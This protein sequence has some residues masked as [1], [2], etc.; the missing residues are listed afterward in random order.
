MWDQIGK[1]PQNRDKDGSS[2]NFFS[3]IAQMCYFPQAMLESLG[4]CNVH[5]FNNKSLP[6]GGGGG[7]ETSVVTLPAIVNPK[8]DLTFKIYIV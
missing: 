1:Q 4:F 5:A 7:E 6:V 8:K 2:L 3:E